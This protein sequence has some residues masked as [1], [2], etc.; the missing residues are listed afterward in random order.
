MS[1]Q[2]EVHVNACLK[3]ADIVILTFVSFGFVL[4]KKQNKQTNIIRSR[5]FYFKILEAEFYKMCFSE[6]A[7]NLV[8]SYG[9]VKLVHIGVVF[10]KI[11]FLHGCLYLFQDAE[12][13]VTSC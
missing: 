1:K 5:I 12:T 9:C 2:K 8:V 10:D 13:H 11:I 4:K 7:V 3:D 6:N